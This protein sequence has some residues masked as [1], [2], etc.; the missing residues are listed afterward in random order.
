MLRMSLA[1]QTVT[2]IPSA[3][4]KDANAAIEW[5]KRVLG[6]TEH[7]VYRTPDGAVQHA[8][9]LFGNGMFMLGT[10]GLNA[11]TAGLN[12]TPAECGGRTTGGSY[13]IVKDCTPVWERAKAAGAEIVLPLRTMSYGGQAF[14][15][16]D[17]EGQMW[18]LG[19]YDP[20]TVPAA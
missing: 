15:V 11:E 12:T 14:T 3:A 13:L 16:R 20:W 18:S 5:L 10:V 2:V 9:L 8:E 6:F 1:G 4:Y 17:P 7:A 19:E